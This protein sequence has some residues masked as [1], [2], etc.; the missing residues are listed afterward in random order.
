MGGGKTVGE[1]DDEKNDEGG[2]RGGGGGEGGGDEDKGA[3][4]MTAVTEDGVVKF[5]GA[6]DRFGRN[7]TDIDFPLSSF[8]PACFSINELYFL[9]KDE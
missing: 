8:F 4:V 6:A 7:L 9:V 3:G 1:E 2:G 5:W